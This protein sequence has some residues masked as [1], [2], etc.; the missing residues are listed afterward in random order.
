MLNRQSMLISVIIII[1]EISID[2]LSIIDRLF[3]LAESAHSE[4]ELKIIGP[5]Y[6]TPSHLKMVTL[7]LFMKKF[8]DIKMLNYSVLGF[9]Y[10]PPGGYSYG[11]TFAQTFLAGSHTFNPNKVE[12]F[13]SSTTL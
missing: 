6:S 11:S 8:S 9:C 4:S 13:Y 2:C 1:T 12:T 7:S 10:R 5:C 3:R